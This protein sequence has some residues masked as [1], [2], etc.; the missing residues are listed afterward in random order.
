[1]ELYSS[2]LESLATEGAASQNRVSKAAID[3]LVGKLSF[4]ARAYR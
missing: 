2:E 3:F 1:M 4:C